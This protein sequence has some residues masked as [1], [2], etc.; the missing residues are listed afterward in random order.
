MSESS[1]EFFPD[2][3]KIEYK[4]ESKGDALS[5]KHYNPDEVILGKPMK[6]WLRFSVCFWHTFV[7]G[8]GADPFGSPTYIRDWEG[9]LEGIEL[10][11]RRIDV[12][13][14]FF[15]KLGIEYYCFHGKRS[16]LFIYSF[17][18]ISLKFFDLDSVCVPISKLINIM[19]VDSIH[20]LS[21]LFGR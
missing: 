14:E 18:F 13:F 2:I 8:G 16:A 21:I 7:G 10:A 6:E 17:M 5:F 9:D 12:A 11:K 19:Y 15:T 3:S 4:P 1:K 20:Y